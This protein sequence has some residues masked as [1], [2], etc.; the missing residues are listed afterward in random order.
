[1]N[2]E[3]KAQFEIIEKKFITSHFAAL[4]WMDAI[5]NIEPVMYERFFAGIFSPEEVYFKLRVIKS[6][7]GLKGN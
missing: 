6:S 1:T 5:V 7:E 4:K 2:Y 3:G